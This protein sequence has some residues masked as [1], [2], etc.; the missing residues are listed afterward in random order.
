MN[1]DAIIPCFLAGRRGYSEEPLAEMQND[2]RLGKPARLVGSQ[3]FCCGDETIQ[4]RRK[5]RGEVA[6]LSLQRVK[7]KLRKGRHWKRAR[8]VF[9]DKDI[10]HALE[11]SFGVFMILIGK[12][13]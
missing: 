12:S 2:F 5:I 1:L 3:S 6:G 8:A 13:G 4:P 10:L 11:R 7:T 9:F